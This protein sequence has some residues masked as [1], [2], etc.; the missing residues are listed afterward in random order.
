MTN[1]DLNCLKCGTPATV[2]FEYC[3]SC[4]ERLPPDAMADGPAGRDSGSGAVPWTVGHVGIALF[5]FVAVL[6]AAAFIARAI[7]PLY[8]KYETAL[9]TW[10]AVHLLA[11]GIALVVWGMGLRL[12]TNPLG[13]LG[14]VR[15]RTS[16]GMTILLS[17]AALAFS[18]V[19]T[20][21]YGF[22]VEQLGLEALRPPDIRTEA[23]FPGAGILLTLQALALITPISEEILFRGYVLRGLL[24]QIGSGPAVVS[25]ALVFSALHFDAGT[26]IPI[27]FTG[28]ALGWLSVKTGSLWPCIAAH[29]GQNLLALQ[30]VRAGL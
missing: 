24:N 1:K 16:R 11:A 6:F 10:V 20:F 29:A 22:I 26:M 8:P 7:G 14:L 13:A 5:L 2:G 18:I 25:T 9:E 27:F 4:G 15:P 3:S 17:V 30:A 21:A 28:L 19:A 12:T 23:L